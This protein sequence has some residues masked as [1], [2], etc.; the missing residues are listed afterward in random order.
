MP[1]AMTAGYSQATAGARLC[2]ER[3]FDLI[4]RALAQSGDGPFCFVDYGA[5]DGGTATGLYARVAQ[6][7]RGRS[8][9]VRVLL[10]DLP[11][12]DFE[13]LARNGRAAFA[14]VGDVEVVRHGFYEP[15]SEPNSVSLGFS[16]TAMHWLRAAPPHVPNHTHGNANNEPEVRAAFAERAVADFSALMALR[17]DE[18]APGGAL[19]LVNLARDDQDHY[20]GWNGRD[21]NMHDE[22]HRLWLELLREGRIDREAYRRANFQNFYKSEAEFARVFEDEGSEAYRKGLRLE[23]MR[24]ER[25]ACPYRARFD[26]DKDARTFG[27]GLMGTVQSWSRHTFRTALDGHPETEAILE[28]LYGRFAETVAARPERFSMDYVQNYLLAR[29]VA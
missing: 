11:D 28:L 25:I 24:T 7:V 29:K 27:Q 2:L 4:D 18:L 6:R 12:N 16:A 15:V 20:L 22:L 21:L 17:A 23:A 9:P 10:E 13:T 5:A 3:S 19:V 14:E 26:E 1:I 8:G